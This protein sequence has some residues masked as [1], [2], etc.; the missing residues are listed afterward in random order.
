MPK[1]TS[2]RAC[3]KTSVL[4]LLH[5]EAFVKPRQEGGAI[6]VTSSAMIMSA[7]SRERISQKAFSRRILVVS[8]EHKGA[9]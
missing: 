3:G 7:K 5:V 9:S 4:S 6:V 1:E 2:S 8:S